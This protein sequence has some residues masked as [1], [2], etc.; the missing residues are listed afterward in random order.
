MA[1]DLALLDEVAAGALPALRLYQ[2]DTPALSLGRFQPE[3]DVETDAC[4]RMGVE[5]VRRPTGGRALLHG[6]DLTYAVVMRRPEGS[7]GT[8]EALYRWFAHGLVTGLAHLGV[9]ADIGRNDRTAGPA[10]FAGQQGAD[11]RV[12]ERKLCGSAQVH[13]DGAV[14]QHGSIRARALDFD[15]TALLRYPTPEAR[16]VAARELARAA[17]TLAELGAPHDARR[18]AAAVVDGFREA[19]DLTWRSKAPSDGPPAAVPSRG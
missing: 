3:T 13:R 10:C 16:S 6:G 14:L 1:A 5:V 9:A 12:G 17:T 18:V 11:L 7:S 15:E 4:R 2:W 19:L 8:I